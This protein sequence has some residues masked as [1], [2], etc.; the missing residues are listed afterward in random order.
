MGKKQ[1]GVSGAGPGAGPG[2]GS[3]A[4]D[5]RGVRRSWEGGVGEEAADGRRVDRWLAETARVVTRSQL[6]ARGAVIL[7]NGKESKPS[8]P[9][10]PGDRVSVSWIEEPSEG[11]VPEDLPL[12]VLYEDERT[13][14]VDKAQGM[15]THPGHGNRRGTL[16]NA[17]L[18][19]LVA[20]GRGAAPRGGPGGA[21]GGFPEAP[22]SF[23]GG[24][25]HRLDKDTSGVIVAA[26]DPA[27]QAALAAQFKDRTTRK[28]YLAVTRGVP[29]PAAGRVENRLG[30]DPRERK[31]FAAVAEGGKVAVTD[32]RV[33]AVYGRYALVALRPKTGRTHQLR[34]HLA[35]LGAPI[36]GDPVYG[37]R[38]SDFSAATLMLHAFRLRIRLP[39][40]EEASLFK[41][42]LPSRFVALLA[43]LERRYGKK[44][45]A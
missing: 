29:A 22:E 8:R 32:Y 16:A 12:S 41:A 27:A 2:A 36:L 9:L 4:E 38:D 6:K 42:P 21:P 3:G 39:G 18:G 23:R 34:V 44:T 43:E 17:L 14:V 35:G 10:K 7:V 33:L 26:K 20:A 28:E 11:L 19:R 1:R 15:V 30:R 13:I 45:P 5:A 31:R 24:V 37:K 25:V 40:K